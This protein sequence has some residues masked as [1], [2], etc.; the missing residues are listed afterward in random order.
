MSLTLRR[1]H[2]LLARPLLAAGLALLLAG[3]N[4]GGDS[5]SSGVS[6]ATG[7]QTGVD[8]NPPVI[9]S[10]PRSQAVAGTKYDYAPNAT[11]PDGDSL[12]FAIENQPDWA[13]FDAESGRLSGTPLEA[14]VGEY[15]R[16]TIAARDG[17][18][19]SMV[20][21]FKITVASSTGEPAPEPA[22]SAPTISG[23]PPAQ[24]SAGTSYDFTPGSADADGDTLTFSIRNRP[25]WATFI[26]LTGRLRGTPDAG[27][28]GTYT[29]IEITASDGTETASL[30][31][32][33]IVVET[34]ASGG[35]SPQPNH[36]PSI[37][38]TP[39]ASVVA[40]KSY[41]FTPGATDS[42]ADALTFAISGK[43]GW[44]AFSTSTGRLSG[45][46][47]KGAVGVYG[48]I[49]I[50]VSDGQASAALPAFAIEVLP[51]PNTAPVISGKPPAAVTAG[52]AYSFTPQASDADGDALTFS[53]AGKPSWATFSTL[54]GRLSG[55]PTDA[56]VRTWSGVAIKVSDG[57]ANASL[58][59]FAIEVEQ[60]S[61][62][63]VTLTWTA[64]TQNTD[65]SPL[66]D[67][68]GYRIVYGKS[69]GNLDQRIAIANAGITTA[70][71]EN[72]A[73]GTW[74]FAVRALNS[75][76]IASDPSQAASKAVP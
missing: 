59:Q 45:T 19:E 54:T 74:Y 11:D 76:Q 53:I 20:G 7:S 43:P 6:A 46:P 40:G 69:S 65:G 27:D 51:P 60:T 47:A 9:A 35:S 73:S 72:L 34:A 70:V 49:R 57:Q 30:E 48:S 63:S 3:C 13:E 28:V 26:R 12:T 55:T 23:S 8:N 5:G 31:P 14:D 56:D 24:I 61:L 38:G 17:R 2:L 10:S 22:N 44:A 36:A 52:T 68:A 16:I 33:S 15:P 41:S 71:V 1:N 18:A 58:P 39:N 50:T 42:D 64:P 25:A 21:P 75:A 66:V 4:E 32:F 62:G 37:S 29:G 67:L